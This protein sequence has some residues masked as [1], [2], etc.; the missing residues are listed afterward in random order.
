MPDPAALPG[1][2]IDLLRLSL[3]FFVL[4]AIFVP[5]ERAVALHGLKLRRAQFGNDLI[6]FFLSGLLPKIL[7]APPM[8]AIALAFNALL[9]QALL[10]WTTELPLWA[11]ALGAML[12][13][14]IGFY[15]GHR[16]MH[17]IPLLW[18]FHAVHHSAESIDWLVNTRLHPVD[19][20]FTRLCG[21]VPMYALG[22]VHP[23]ANAA[24]TLPLLVILIGTMWGFF[25]HANMRLRFGPLE[26]VISTPAFHHWHHS[27]IDHADHNYAS[28]FPWLD[29]LFGTFY[30][31]RH[32]PADYGTQKPVADDFASQIVE[33]FERQA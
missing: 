3:W 13:G 8:A 10:I 32:W 30:L 2:V 20:I 28:M 7:L 11:R 14:E 24:D 17:E 23:Q 18:R 33:P 16:W 6:Y 4:A 15:W 27:R 26:N 19:M 21:F 12:A 5:L 31:P 22:F 1:I 9:P 25:I 29:R